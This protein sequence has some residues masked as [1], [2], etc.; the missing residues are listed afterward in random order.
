MLYS[1]RWAQILCWHG[2]I[3]RFLF[4][5]CPITISAHI[6]N[7]FKASRRAFSICLLFFSLSNFIVFIYHRAVHKFIHISAM[8]MRVQGCVYPMVLNK[9]IHK[10]NR[11][12]FW[13]IVRHS[14]DV[15]VVVV[16]FSLSLPAFS[17]VSLFPASS[18]CLFHVPSMPFQNMF[19]SRAT[20]IFCKHKMKKK[21]SKPTHAREKNLTNVTN[22]WLPADESQLMKHSTDW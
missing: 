16:V 21:T 17:L 14:T 1:T 15:V 10:P 20:V 18:P 5:V 11:T 19:I 22:R 3:F 2:F 9:F 13:A 8:Q 4:T 12:K 6:I 7:L